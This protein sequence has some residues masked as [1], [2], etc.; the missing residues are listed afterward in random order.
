[1][2]GVNTR[3]TSKALVRDR[4]G[5]PRWRRS[6][7]AMAGAALAVSAIAACD[8]GSAVGV[9][10]ADPPPVY[11]GR[12][13]SIEDWGLRLQVGSGLPQTLGWADSADVFRQVTAAPTGLRDGDCVSVDFGEPIAA[14]LSEVTVGALYVLGRTVAGETLGASAKECAQAMRNAS[15][16][17]RIAGNLAGVGVGG[18]LT[19][20]GAVPVPHRVGQTLGTVSTTR[21]S[22]ASGPVTTSDPDASSAPVL[23]SRLTLRLSERSTIWITERVTRAD[24]VVGS[25]ATVAVTR[26]YGLPAVGRITLHPD[27]LGVC[28]RVTDDSAVLVPMSIWVTAAPTPTGPTTI[29]SRKPVTGSTG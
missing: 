1:M 9:I 10:P 18:T 23:A 3:H 25:C 19:L 28:G 24:T 8:S 22:A 27:V 13:Q 16:P 17:G 14:Q 21:A 6:G 26:Q 5:W 15:A 12:V 4:A 20:V 29:P 7:A 2:V 11:V